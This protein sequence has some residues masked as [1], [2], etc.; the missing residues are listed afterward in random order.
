[1]LYR[2]YSFLFFISL[3]GLLS[4]GEENSL[5][6]EVL[7]HLSIRITPKSVFVLTS[8]RQIRISE[9]DTLSLTA[10]STQFQL[11]FDNTGGQV[12]VT[13]VQAI[14]IVTDPTG[15]A[16]KVSIDP[17]ANMFYMSSGGGIAFV[18]RNIIVEIQR[19]QKTSCMSK[20]DYFNVEN[21]VSCV[22]ILDDLDAGKSAKGTTELYF[23]SSQCCHPYGSVNSLQDIWFM[24]GGLGGTSDEEIVSNSYSF[25]MKLVGWIGSVSNPLANFVTYISF[26]SSS[27]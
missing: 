24:V 26:R 11:H 4:C 27:L 5:L 8:D 2:R 3:F 14:L 16:T 15:K 23:D 18:E 17:L 19:Y 7:K 6:S 21:H 12:P 1:M 25:N 13:I 10:P 9:E 20:A 22:E